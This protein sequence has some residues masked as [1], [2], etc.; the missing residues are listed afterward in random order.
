MG[1]SALPARE[2]GQQ[3]YIMCGDQIK[4]EPVWQSNMKKKQLKNTAVNDCLSSMTAGLTEKSICKA[5]KSKREQFLISQK[6]ASSGA[7]QPEDVGLTQ[8]VKR[9]SASRGQMRTATINLTDQRMMTQKA[10][11]NTSNRLASEGRF[12]PEAHRNAPL[13]NM[14]TRPQTCSTYTRG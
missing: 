2:A 3:C 7:L 5:T 8:I 11:L 13:N 10:M 12:Q 4:Y 9:R 6:R 1:L 14:G